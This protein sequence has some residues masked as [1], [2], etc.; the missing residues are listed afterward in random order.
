MLLPKGFIPP[1]NNNEDY[2]SEY[3]SEPS[4]DDCW[5]AVGNPN[6]KDDVPSEAQVVYDVARA[7]RK[8]KEHESEVKYDRERRS[9][10]GLQVPVAYRKEK[11]VITWKVCD[12]EDDEL[13]EKEKENLDEIGLTNFN[14]RKLDIPD[15]KGRLSRINFM[16]LFYTLWPGNIH[17]QLLK[18]NTRIELDNLM[19]SKHKVRPVSVREFTRFLGILLIAR[20]EGKKGG[21]LWDGSDSEGEGYRSQCDMSRYMSKHRHSQLRKYFSFIFADDG[22]KPTDPWWMV[23]P[24]IRAFNH[25]RRMLF[26]PSSTLVM[27]EAMSAY[28]PQTTATGE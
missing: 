3:D 21:N 5:S 14:F 25:N 10:Q 18:L 8:A 16:K 9:L 19:K 4:S 28:V 15:S 6:P 1:P 13:V 24:G 12:D 11:T 2:D 23:S 7:A 27:D 26:R 22:L 20:L 17:H